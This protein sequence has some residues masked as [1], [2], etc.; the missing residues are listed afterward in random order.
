M[1][2]SDR[3]SFPSRFYLPTKDPVCGRATCSRSNHSLRLISLALLILVSSATLGLP[4]LPDRQRR[5]QQEPVRAQRFF[6]KLSNIEQ[7]F[8]PGWPIMGW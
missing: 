3:P 8:I 6:M 5:L 2:E 7:R 4:N 1:I